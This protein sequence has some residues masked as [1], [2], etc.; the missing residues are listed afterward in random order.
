MKRVG[1]KMIKI[2]IR[3]RK[4][5][6]KRWKQ[7]LKR[8]KG[9][10]WGN[11]TSIWKIRGKGRTGYQENMQIILLLKRNK[12]K[13]KKKKKK[14]IQRMRRGNL[15]LVFWT[16]LSI[17][18]ERRK[19]NRGKKKRISSLLLCRLFRRRCQRK[20]TRRSRVIRILLLLRIR[21]YWPRILR[22]SCLS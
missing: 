14:K 1:N 2:M 5:S 22:I 16:K 17:G 18:Q 20:R 11:L 4:N 3:R 10:N 19:R 8:N 21:N 12:K 15:S 6:S 7:N 9:R 13:N